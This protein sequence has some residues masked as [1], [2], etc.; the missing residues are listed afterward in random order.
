MDAEPSL[1]GLLKGLHHIPSALIS[2]LLL[3]ALDV[4]HVLTRVCGKMQ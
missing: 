2:E 4:N 3:Y 1:F